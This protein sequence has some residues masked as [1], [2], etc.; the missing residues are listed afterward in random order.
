MRA[1]RDWSVSHAG[2]MQRAYQAWERLLVSIDPLASAR[3]AEC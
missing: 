2:A 3:A 1:V